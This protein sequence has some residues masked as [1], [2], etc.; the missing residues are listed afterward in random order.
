MAADWKLRLRTLRVVEAGWVHAYAAHTRV[1]AAAADS[2]GVADCDR[3][4]GRHTDCWQHL[5]P[6]LEGN[7]R[8]VASRFP[9]CRHLL[10]F[11]MYGLGLQ[12]WLVKGG[13]APADVLLM[14]QEA[15]LLHTE[16]A[17][18]ALHSFLGIG[19]QS[20]KAQGGE[21]AA[22]G[23]KAKGGDVPGVGGEW[24]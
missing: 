12:L 5:L 3:Y 10:P 14:Q 21:I 22:R 1:T 15:L 4:S 13:I 11:G 7:S 18:A 23:S 6:V 16:E 8:S 9:G 17:L 20:R 2:E 24:Q 19:G